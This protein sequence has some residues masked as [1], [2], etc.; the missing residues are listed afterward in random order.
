MLGSE[1]TATER[2][3]AASGKLPLSFVPKAGQMNPTV[4]FQ[5]RSAGATLFFTSNEIVLSLPTRTAA[6]PSEILNPRS[7]VRDLQP[8]I[9]EVVSKNW[10]I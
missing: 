1:A 4:P 2:L 3:Q 8:T 7:T 5:V 6:D 9:S 10:T